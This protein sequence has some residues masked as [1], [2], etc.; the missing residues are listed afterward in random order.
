M[1]FLCNLQHAQVDNNIMHGSNYCLL[2]PHKGCVIFLEKAVC[3]NLPCMVAVV[4]MK[5]HYACT[6]MLVT[7]KGM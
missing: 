4:E 2:K 3:R 5:M 6:T 7:L 1:Y